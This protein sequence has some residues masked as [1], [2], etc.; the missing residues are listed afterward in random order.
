MWWNASQYLR[1]QKRANTTGGALSPSS[2]RF[3]CDEPFGRVS[4]E[5]TYHIG[6]YEARGLLDQRFNNLLSNVSDVAGL[7]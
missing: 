7:P 3:W 5:A 6:V 4:S 1:G 2:C